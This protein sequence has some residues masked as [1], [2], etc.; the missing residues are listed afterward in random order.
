MLRVER[1]VFEKAVVQIITST[2]LR[3]LIKE[4]SLYRVFFYSLLKDVSRGEGSPNYPIIKKIA[5]DR[6]I[7]E[8]FIVDQAKF[9]LSQ[10]A[11]DEPEEDYYKILNVPSTASAEEIRESWLNLVKTYHPDNVGDQGLN[12]TKKLNEAYSVLGDPV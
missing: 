8:Q 9:V 12:V 11:P 4:F 1:K 3:D 5:R 6:K 7:N 10:L 2:D